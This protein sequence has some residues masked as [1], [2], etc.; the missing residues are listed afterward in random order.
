MQ[1]EIDKPVHRGRRPRFH[2]VQQTT[3]PLVDN[4]YSRL[5]SLLAALMPPEARLI[6]TDVSI[7]ASTPHRAPHTHDLHANHAIY[8]CVETKHAAP[9]IH[10]R[11]ITLRY[12]TSAVY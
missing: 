9:R 4:S 5:M 11:P 10:S 6:A 1:K 8:N 3:P 12:T 7:E 2:H